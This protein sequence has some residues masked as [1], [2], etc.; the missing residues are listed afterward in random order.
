MRDIAHNKELTEL[1]SP[2]NISMYRLTVE[3]DLAKRDIV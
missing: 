3:L 1:S 2:D